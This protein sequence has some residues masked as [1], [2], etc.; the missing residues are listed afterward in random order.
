[1]GKHISFRLVRSAAAWA[2]GCL[3]FCL[4]I[5]SAQNNEIIA[6]CESFGDTP[7]D[8]TDLTIEG[9]VKV[10]VPTSM[11][12]L[13]DDVYAVEVQC[14]AS[15]SLR[16][17]QDD[18]VG[19]GRVVIG[20]QDDITMFGLND[21]IFISKFGVF[22]HIITDHIDTYSDKVDVYMCP[23]PNRELAS[24]THGVCSFGVHYGDA[25]V[26]GLDEAETPLDCTRTEEV[27]P[28]AV[29]AHPGPDTAVVEAK[30]ARLGFDTDGTPI[31]YEALYDDTPLPGVDDD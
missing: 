21:T 2:L 1:M 19:V 6:T 15:S 24:W 26:D 20:S 7:S 16:P 3:A 10:T 29:C 11:F 17:K 30:F 25:G 13:T 22:T 14:E 12:E 4:P 18:V 8:A 23:K 27:E 5:A 31:D 28:I 9:A